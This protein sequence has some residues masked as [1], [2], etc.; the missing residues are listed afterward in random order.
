MAS[1]ALHPI[2]VNTD[3]GDFG[4]RCEFAVALALPSRA[5]SMDAYLT[6]CC[7]NHH[8]GKSVKELQDLQFR[9]HPLTPETAASSRVGSI[10]RPTPHKCNLHLDHC[11][12]PPSTLWR[13]PTT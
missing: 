8:F 4:S 11:C 2:P 9:Y 12:R 3:F 1:D 5:V 10:S 7:I 13:F 6:V